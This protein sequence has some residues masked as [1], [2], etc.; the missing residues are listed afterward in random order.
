MAEET[1]SGSKTED[2]SPRKLEEARRRGEVPKSH[3]VV[4]FAA[5]AAA[6]GVLLMAGGG[7]AHGMADRLRP[8]ISRPD[9]FDLTNGGAVVVLQ[10]ALLAAAPAMVAVLGAVMLAGIGA[11][12]IQHGFI[13]TAAPLALNP[14][15]LSP[16]QGFKRLFGI[17]GFSQFLKSA[18]KIV[19]VGAIAWFIIAPHA[20]E[21]EL[22]PALAPMALLPMAAQMMRA[23]LFG[24]LAFLAVVAGFDWFWQRYRFMQRMRMT[25]EELKEDFKQ[26]EGDPRIKARIRQLRNDRARRRMMQQV[27]KATV[28]VMNPTHYAVALRYVAGETPAPICVAKGLDLVALRIREVAE[29]HRVPVIEDPPLARGLYAT[30]EMDEA[31]PRQHY[32]AVAKIIGFIMQTARA[33]AGRP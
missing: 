2:A 22:L 32:D 23:L 19:V 6:S 33:R 15:R 17:D 26:A 9:D 7:L 13:L 27:P 24:V 4:S 21:F 5:L 25:K 18:L 30:V 29:A 20:R 12:L 8:F 28:V 11:N 1:D 14:D 3:D 31:I 10:Q 16:L